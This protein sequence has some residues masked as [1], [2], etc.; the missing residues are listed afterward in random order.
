GVIDALLLYETLARRRIDIQRVDDPLLGPVAGLKLFEERC[1]VQSIEIIAPTATQITLGSH[2]HAITSVTQFRGAKAALD[3][4]APD[5]NVGLERSEIAIAVVQAAKLTS[6]RI[7]VR[8]YCV[9]AA[10][11]L[12]LCRCH[13]RVIAVE[14][15][16]RAQE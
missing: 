8:V 14:V 13:Q 5:R 4:A 11:L 6:S 12:L 1:A 15:E 16:V 9:E 7:A 10:E 3:T 2:Q